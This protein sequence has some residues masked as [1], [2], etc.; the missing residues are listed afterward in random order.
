M[1]DLFTDKPKLDPFDAKP[2]DTRGFDERTAK[3]AHPKIAA[4]T[5]KALD[6]DD[7]REIKAEFRER[8][9]TVK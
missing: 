2:S 3:A 5:R 1:G 7:P 9:A 4:E 8:A 6:C